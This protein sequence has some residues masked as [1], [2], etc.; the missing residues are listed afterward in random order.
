MSTRRLRC[1]GRPLRLGRRIGRGGEGEVF[2]IRGE[3][4]LAVKLYAADKAEARADKIAAMVAA[5]LDTGD[6]RVAFPIAIVEDAGGDFVGFTMPRVVGAE[7][8]HELYAPGPRKRSFPDADYRFLVRAALNAA[9][10]VAATHAAGCVVGDV[11][12]SSF[13][14][15]QDALVTLIDAD[16]FQFSDGRRHHLCRVGVPEYTAPELIGAPL[17]ETVRTPA[18]DGFGLAVVLFQLL[19]MGRHPFAGVSDGGDVPVAEAIERHA[20][21]YSRRRVTGLRPPPAACTLDDLPDTVADLFERAFDG[22]HRRPAAAE[23]VAALAEFE[24]SLVRCR[25][26]PQHHHAATA[27]ACPWCRMERHTGAPL[28]LLPLSGTDGLPVPA[29]ARYDASAA[30]A[31]VAALR[32]PDSIAYALPP[33]PG[34]VEPARTDWR[35]TAFTLV[36]GCV[37]VCGAWLVIVSPQ[38]WLM[39]MPVMIYGY[40]RV[41]DMV[42]PAQATRRA[43]TRID[44][45][46]AHAIAQVQR[47]VD[48]DAAWLRAAEV[49]AAIAARAIQPAEL[50]ASDATLTEEAL[51]DARLK[52]LDGFLIAGAGVPEIDDRTAAQLSAD[53]IDTAADLRQA[54]TALSPWLTPAQRAA[55]LGWGGA[56]LSGFRPNRALAPA[57]RVERAARRRAVLA[58]ARKLEARIAAGLAELERHRVRLETALDGPHEAVESLRLRREALAARLAMLGEE[59]PELPVPAPRG[60]RSDTR[61]RAA[62]IRV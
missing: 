40:G 52:H 58:T 37:M 23:W 3:P 24:A 11:N 42:Q 46:L 33:L 25:A 43:L 16:S 41:R 38:A 48:L 8:L 59:P 55:L 1:A 29:L 61:A 51:E 17:A 50:A 36:V 2:A 44:E 54:G 6:G 60:L 56:C 57:L 62:A 12:H 26:T 47:S 45:K 49:E 5:H 53:G 14:I 21:A 20:F 13:L 9:R 27:R 22:G 4:T 28:F 34:P 30:M 18:H 7:P 15:G 31:R 10:A 39:T 35:D 19:C 32:P